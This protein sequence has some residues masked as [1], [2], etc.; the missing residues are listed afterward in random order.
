[1]ERL[2][3]K[4]INLGEVEDRIEVNFRDVFEYEPAK[5]GAQIS[6]AA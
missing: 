6:V 4:E 1:M 5:V 3:G 2:L